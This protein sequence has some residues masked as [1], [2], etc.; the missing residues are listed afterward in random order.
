[1]R[2]DLCTVSLVDKITRGKGGG[3]GNPN[4]PVVVFRLPTIEGAVIIRVEPQK[5]G[6]GRLKM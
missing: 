4:N 2:N 3:G 1:M 6:W 5:R